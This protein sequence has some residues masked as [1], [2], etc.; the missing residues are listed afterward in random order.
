MSSIQIGFVNLLACIEN[1]GHKVN[2]TLVLKLN[3]LRDEL[4]DAFVEGIDARNMTTL[5]GGEL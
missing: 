1:R 4:S 2:L 3:G 5:P